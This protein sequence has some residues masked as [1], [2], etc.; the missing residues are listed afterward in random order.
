MIKKLPIIRP[1]IS[2]KDIILSLKLTHNKSVAAD[3]TAVLADFWG[4]RNVYLTNSGIAAFYLILQALKDKSDKKEVVLP[5]YTAGSLVVAVRKA[6]LKV[7]L[8]DVSLEDFNANTQALLQAISPDTLAVVAVHMFG[9]PIGDIAE[10]KIKIPREVWLIEDCAQAMGTRI[11]DKPVGSF[12]DISFFSFKRG[13]NFPI[14]G[15][16]CI[17]SQNQNIAGQL[18]YF[19]SGL[20]QPGCLNGL[21]SFAKSL[22]YLVGTNPYVYGLGFP[23]I[24]H[25][26]ETVPSSD[27]SVKKLDYFEAGLGLTLMKNVDA[28]FLSRYKKGTVLL[29]GLKDVPGIVLPKIPPKT[30]PVFNRIPILCEDIEVLKRVEKKLWQKGIDSSRLYLEPLHHRFE[31]G[32]KAT[33]FPNAVYLARHLLTLPVY[34]GL[35]DKDLEKII[36]TVRESL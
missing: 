7:V 24:S 6:G 25:F 31:L 36:D 19:L 8:C 13:K 21:V 3:F 30:L 22:G 14:F 32:Y 20:N 28:L 35:T 29:E 16:G 12:G 10:L 9:V 18:E 33:D 2:I 15:G 26:K 11:L 23:L 1:K 34:P 4:T 17:V 5:A 27:F